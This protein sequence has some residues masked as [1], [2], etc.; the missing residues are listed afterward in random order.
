MSALRRLTLGL[1]AAGLASAAYAGGPL[2]TFDAHNRI[3]YAWDLTRWP[4]GKVPVYT[5]LGDLGPLPNARV[6]QMVTYATQQWSNVST[7]SFRNQVAGDFSAL[8]LPDIDDTNIDSVIGTYNGGGIDIVYDTDGSIMTNFFGVDPTSVLGI[9]DIDFVN[10]GT[11]EILEA[12]I[13]LSGPGVRPDD[14]NGVGFRGVVTHEMGHSL[15]L[16]HTQTNGAVQY[17]TILD[18]P[19]P[20]GCAA[21]WNGTP[22]VAQVETMYPITTPDPG[23]TG[24]YQG[25]IHMLDDRSALSYLYPAAG[26]PGNYG[27]IRGTIRDASGNPVIGVNVIARNVA[28]PFA[29]CNSFISGQITKGDD[30]LDGSF[31]L[32][33]LTPGARYVLYVDKLEDG[34]FSVPRALVLPGPDEYFN[35]DMESADSS[36]DN[37]CSW[38][39]IPSN[40]GAPETADVTFQKYPGAPTFLLASYLSIPTAITPDGSVI[41]GGYDTNQPIF[42]WDLNAGTF[43]NLGG[44]YLGSPGISDDGSK[45]SANYVAADGISYPAIY[46]NG[47]WTT[48]PPVAGSVACDDSGTGPAYGGAYGI[49]GDGNTVVG[50]SYGNLGCAPDTIRGF[51]W[52]SAG[53]SVALPKVNT[54]AQPGRASAVNYDGSTIVGFDQASTGFRRGVVWKNGV[55]TLILTAAHNWVGESLGVTRDGAYVIGAS[56]SSATSGQAYKYNVAT[57]AVTLFGNLGPGWDGA[58]AKAT[59]DSVGVVGGYSSNSSGGYF[60]STIWTPTLHWFDFNSFLQAQGVNLDGITVGNTTGMSADGR[61]MT[62]WT[63]TQYGTVG[64]ALKTATSVVCHVPAGGPP[65]TQSVVFPQGLDSALQAGDTL[66]P[67]GCSAATPTGT[68]VLGFNDH[69]TFSW[70]TVA[71]ATGYDVAR[72]TLTKLRTNGGDFTTATTDCMESALSTTSSD[73]QETPRSGDGF[74]YLVRAMTC[75]GRGTYDDGSLSQMSDRDG[76]IHDSSVACP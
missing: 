57:K 66:G 22:T 23:Q 29:D 9:T 39:T 71:G 2:Y 72:G 30:G 47:T 15:N 55:A 35:G 41:V 33:G 25:T 8:G 7:S 44:V 13:V 63:A 46:Q 24:Q 5:D 1:V 76:G 73:D 68:P 10:T 17:P 11:S 75:G 3:P 49:S 53:G 52:T 45:I 69:A 62:G 50:L 21:P 58:I 16:A 65:Q 26:Y 38:T 74:W 36:S 12:F 56:N 67:C 70:T 51:K 18:S 40:P 61:V 20:S 31:E 14:P 43:D 59:N 60:T 34:G 19:N 28:S 6:G 27:T 42:R 4:D 48:L 37:R 64:F 32:D 54:F